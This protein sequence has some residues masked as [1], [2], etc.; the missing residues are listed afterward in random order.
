MKKI[1]CIALAAV[2]SVSLLASCSEKNETDTN[3]YR[4]IEITVSDDSKEEILEEEEET[5][6]TTTAVPE[7]TEPVTSTTPVVEIPDKY[8]SPHHNDI[9]KINNTINP[10]LSTDNIT[11]TTT[12][13]TRV[14]T[15]Y[16]SWET[17]QVFPKDPAPFSKNHYHYYQGPFTW[18]GVSIKF[19]VPKDLVLTMDAYE[20]PILFTPDKAADQNVISEGAI[21]FEP[22]AIQKLDKIES[23]EDIDE[24]WFRKSTEYTGGLEVYEDC[25]FVYATKNRSE[26]LDMSNAKFEKN[27]DYVAFTYDFYLTVDNVDTVMTEMFMANGTSMT[28]MAIKGSDFE[29]HYMDY[30]KEIAASFE[31]SDI[32]YIP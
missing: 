16:H 29:K 18:E 28:A 7:D 12:T 5:T 27:D 1:N 14:T 26:G 6:T 25:Q 24:E 3:D 11:E 10:N 21:K 32:E 9:Q 30:M 17:N 31:Y 13:T 20:V 19:D 2:L 15:S 22:F 4:D 23:I 8:T